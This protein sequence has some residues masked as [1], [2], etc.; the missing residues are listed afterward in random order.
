MEKVNENKRANLANG[1]AED[2]EA[3]NSRNG[4]NVLQKRSRQESEHTVESEVLVPVDG[5]IL[6]REVAK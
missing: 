3:K 4:E 1:N 2:V 6:Q 5:G